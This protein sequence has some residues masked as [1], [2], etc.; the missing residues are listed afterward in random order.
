MSARALVLAAGLGTRLRPLTDRVPK[1]LVEIRGRP[2]LDYWFEALRRAG[3]RDV[4]VNT[5]HLAGAVREYLGRKRRE[6]FNAVEAHE[7]ALRGSAGT[8]AANAQWAAGCDEVLVV[9][10]DNFS[11]VDLGAL[12]E[13]HRSHGDPFTMLLFQAPDPGACGIVELDREGR[14]LSFEEKPAAPRS[15]LANAGVYVLAAEAWAEIAAMRAFDLGFD[16]LPAFAGRMRGLRH[17]GVHIDIGDAAALERARATAASGAKSL[18]R[19]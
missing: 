3:I 7:P 18:A 16:V 14:I 13:F 11:S 10:G 6:G 2:L 17:G 12:L 9:Y 1:C 19:S 4:L 15:D 5:H 8:I